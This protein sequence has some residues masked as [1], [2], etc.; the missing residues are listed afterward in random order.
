MRPTTAISALSATT[1]SSCSTSSET[2]EG[3]K[4]RPG[5]VHSAHNW[6]DVL[7]PI[8]SR[9][10]RTGVRRYFR[11]DAAFAKPGVY[12]YL[13]ER[14]VL[15]AIRLP[16]NEVLQWETAPLLRKPVGR[17]PRK[18]I[19]WYDD[20]WYQAGV[21]TAPGGWWP[22]WSG[23]GE[24]CSLGWASSS[25]TCRLAL[26]GYCISTMAEVLPSRGSKRASTPRTGPGSRVTGSLLT[27]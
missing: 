26:K 2:C 22:R 1:H 11:A 15:Y 10:E 16:G 9:Y 17:L 25:P 5:N 3:A 19:I 18:P 24:S 14:R 27:R 20:F 13:E 7:E 12:E 23:T 21:G 6:R 8:L 4:L